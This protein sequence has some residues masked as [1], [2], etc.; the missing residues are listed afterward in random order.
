MSMSF[1]MAKLVSDIL[2]DTGYKLALAFGDCDGI[3][4]DAPCSLGGM[5]VAAT[6]WPLPGFNPHHTHLTA[7]EHG[8]A[9]KIVRSLQM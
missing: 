3:V 9:L 5:P 8:I 1:D 6:S 2:R 7:T 4:V